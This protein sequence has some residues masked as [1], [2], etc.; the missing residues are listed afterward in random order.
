MAF[1]IGLKLLFIIEIKVAYNKAIGFILKYDA[2]RV[3]HLILSQ[4]FAGALHR[5]K[6]TGGNIQRVNLVLSLVRY[7]VFMLH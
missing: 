1:N 2:K 4:L 7:Y 5:F 3:F 6:M